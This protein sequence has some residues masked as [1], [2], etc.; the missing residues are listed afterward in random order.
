MR[1]H[2]EQDSELMKTNINLATEYIKMSANS[3]R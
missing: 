2:P 1:K 3:T